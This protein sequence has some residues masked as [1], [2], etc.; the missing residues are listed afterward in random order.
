MIKLAYRA[1]MLALL[2][3]PVVAVAQNNSAI[4]TSKDG[5][6]QSPNRIQEAGRSAGRIAS[7]PVRDVGMARTNIPLAMQKAAEAPY[8]TAGL[9]NCADIS[10]A[11]NE[12]TTVIGPDFKAGEVPKEN[13]AGKLAE[14]GGKTIVNSL[15]PFRGLVR[16]VSGAAP[17]QRRFERAVAASVAR[18][19]FLRGVHTGRK[20]KTK[21]F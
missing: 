14:A 16:E 21:L 4:A 3:L 17:A 9:K 12:L 11:F 1:A 8:A 6:P 10:R 2:T 15:I 18:R 7:Q 20:C 13:R 5:T 19:G